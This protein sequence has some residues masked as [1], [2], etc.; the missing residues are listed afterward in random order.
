MNK[1]TR[2]TGEGRE[3]MLSLLKKIQALAFAKVETELYLD[4]H[5][6]CQAALDYYKKIIEEYAPLAERYENE[7][8][9]IRQENVKGER[10]N[11]TDTPWPWQL[12]G[13][14][15]EI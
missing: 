5:P 10:W 12:E 13:N 2:I 1:E 11:W 6:D 3:D 14:G 15:K 4:A 7:Y 9:T 8:G